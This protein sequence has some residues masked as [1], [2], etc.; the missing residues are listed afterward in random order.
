MI[1]G[2]T[3]SKTADVASVAVRPD[4][5][6]PAS[7]G[8][9]VGR[10]GEPLPDDVLLSRVRG[11][12]RAA[13]GELWRRHAGAARAIAWRYA[14]IADPEDSLQEASRVILAAILRGGGPFGEFRPYLAV[15]VRNSA[16]SM[17]RRHV[18]EPVG[19]VLEVADLTPSTSSDSA[20]S[21]LEGI[22]MARAFKTLPSRWQEVLW[23]VC[24]EDLSMA[25]AGGILGL[26]P[27]ATAALAKRAR[28]G[29]RMAWLEA[30]LSDERFGDSCRELASGYSAYIRDGLSVE[31]SEATAEHLA[32]CESCV[33]LTV[34]IRGSISR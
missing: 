25:Q 15:T 27:N 28:E 7:V 1:A 18:P 9:L 31:R 16:I 33:G 30:H 20:S 6:V 32:G 29:L 17:S 19:D 3:L 13:F 22:V 24:V 23:Y 5:A 11:G 26:S 34:E 8:T 12:D 10:P 14:G 2:S 21:V 4:A